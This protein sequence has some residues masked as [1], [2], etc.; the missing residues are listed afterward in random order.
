MNPAALSRRV[1]EPGRQFSPRSVLFAE[2]F[3]DFAFLPRW[4]KNWQLRS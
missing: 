4:L 2:T 3:Y 1:E